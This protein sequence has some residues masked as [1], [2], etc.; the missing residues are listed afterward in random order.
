[1]GSDVLGILI[2]K[3]WIKY[4]QERSHGGWVWGPEPP[5]PRPGSWDD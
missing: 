2:R 4:K 3:C 1:M 5:H